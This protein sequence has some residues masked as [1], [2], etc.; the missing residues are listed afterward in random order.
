MI[1]HFGFEGLEE[2]GLDVDRSE[3]NRSTIF[4]GLEEGGWEEEEVGEGY[5]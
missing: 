2:E 3:G 4:M 1:F 5:Q